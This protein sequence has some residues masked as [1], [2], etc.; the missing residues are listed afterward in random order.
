MPCAAAWAAGGATPSLL[1]PLGLNIVPS[2]RME[3]PG[4]LRF[5]ASTLDPYV[6]GYLSFQLADSLNIALRQTA[7]VS[8]LNDEADRLYPG[9]DL[10]LRLTEETKYA[11][12]VAIGLISALGHKRMAGEYVAAS[13]RWNAFD[14]T[15]GLGWGRYGSAATF[16]NPLSALG[17]HFDAP[18]A[19]D[20]D[21]P[22]GPEDWFTGPD[23]GLFGGV[24][25]FTPIDGLSLKLDWGA[26]RFVAEKTSFDFDAPAPWSAGVTYTPV[27]G[28][29]LGL[30]IIGGDK[31][32]ASLNLRS[33]V[34]K[35]PGRNRQETTPLAL[36]TI[37]GTPDKTA[38]VSMRVTLNADPD[39]PLPRQI[40]AAARYLAAKTGTQAEEFL[41]A[42][43]IYGFR[44]PTLRLMRR[45]LE[46]AIKHQ[47]SPQEI[48]RSA[49]VAP[50]LPA[51]TAPERGE[52]TLTALSWPRFRL[53]LD[54]QASLSEEDSGILYRT[55][56]ILE[57][58]ERLFRHAV[59]GVGLRFN[60]PNNLGQLEDIR[61]DSSS[62]ARS[63]VAR[64][65]GKTVTLDRLYGAWTKSSGDGQW[66]G[67]LVA[68]YLEEM[69]GG[70][71]GEILYRPFGKTYAFGA[72]LWNAVK[73]D[74]DSAFSGTFSGDHA[75]TGYLKAWYEIPQTDLTVGLKAGRYLAGD[76]GA[77]LSLTKYAENG[78][79][80]EA[81]A[82][83]TDQSDSDP[84]GGTTHLYS[85]LRLTLPIGNA[86]ALPRGSQVRLAAVPLGRDTGQSLDSPMPLYES[87]EPLSYRHITRHWTKVVE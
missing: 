16:G 37:G 54:T 5:G 70:V 17:D 81:F 47:G 31:I 79:R 86:P 66:H 6:H 38:P 26:D 7:F 46:Q 50:S 8:G 34:E 28:V 42:T 75:L 20:G 72:E 39:E 77:T 11:P 10:K 62:S 19:L 32:L 51:S 60:S 41:I 71:G 24:E 35:W 65:A 64:F 36:R 87:T 45:D 85:G 9:V 67:L 74:P 33:L 23:I 3:E 13:K 58:G 63:D 14:F 40:G 18:R 55:S 22:N 12:A 1:G 76:I 30:G 21:M 68:G 15:A 43:D 52:E 49:V 73:R 82:T 53:N 78:A 83:A 59:M 80:I 56:A 44:G 2:A 61:T 4:T 84:F 29:D 25:Y 57:A 27:S 69:Y 48:W